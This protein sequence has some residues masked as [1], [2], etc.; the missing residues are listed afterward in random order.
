MKESSA[1]KSLTIIAAVNLL[2]AL[3]PL[4]AVIYFKQSAAYFA[5]AAIFIGFFTFFSFLW[6]GCKNSGKTIITADIL[7]TAI[8]VSFVLVYIYVVGLTV[9]FRS[10]SEKTQPLT[11]TMVT[12][13]TTI[14][15]VVI[16]FYFT[17]SAI[18]EKGKDAEK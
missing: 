6:Y 1:A 10:W 2:I 7:R 8:T 18:V 11:Q 4:F 3:V 13:F 5:Y 17:A 12:N 14:V 16:A 15:G 9:F